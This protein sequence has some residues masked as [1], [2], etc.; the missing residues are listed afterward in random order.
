[1]SSTRAHRPGA[2]EVAL[3][4]VLTAATFAGTLALLRH[5]GVV[6]MRPWSGTLDP[7]GVALAAL[8]T[9]PL[10]AW[11]RSPMAVFLATAAASVALAGFGYP[12]DVVLGPT[13][14][15]Y[16]L[17]AS[18]DRE[19]PWNRRTTLAVAGLFTA[20]LVAAAFARQGLPG[21]E[22][23]HSGLAWAVAWFAGD[24]S[25]LRRERMEE[26]KERALR[27]ERDAA[28]ESQLAIA[29]ERG[30]IARDLHDSAGHAISVIAVRA[31]AARLRF[32]QDP[33]RSLAALEAIEDLARQTATDIDQIVR[34]LRD[35]RGNPESLDTLIAHHVAAGLDVSVTTEGADGHVGRPV[36]QAVYRIVQEG[37]TNA[38]RHGTGTA[39]VAI[40][41]GSKVLAVTITN[42][43]R[44][45]GSASPGGGHG[46]I[47][48][49]E[50][51]TLLGGTL[52]AKRRNGIF[53]VRAIIPL[54]GGAS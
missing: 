33:A 47:G 27:A 16:L 36:E 37:L 30:R 39:R 15:L 45:N 51:A 31:G 5:G 32:H 54:P 50:R 22:L 52:E 6:P 1:M 13:V 3:D 35:E 8:S 28:R 9:L 14:A 17:A 24:R 20:Y 40:T 21:V 11:R 38:A 18:R 43:V 48:M 44:A 41:F 23:L 2:T 10:A 34:G 53:E 25:R 7:A 42:P 49:R 46:L 19:N 29:E 12:S 4:L 26:F